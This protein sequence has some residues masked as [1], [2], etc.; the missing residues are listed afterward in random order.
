MRENN[1]SCR[2]IHID[3]KLLILIREIRI[4]S[5]C[6]L[7]ILRPRGHGY[8]HIFNIHNYNYTRDI[9]IHKRGRGGLIDFTSVGLAQA[10]PNNYIQPKRVGGGVCVCALKPLKHVNSWLFDL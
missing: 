1:R 8:R 6:L 7:E 9:I 10:H 4:F 2:H 3:L 5:S